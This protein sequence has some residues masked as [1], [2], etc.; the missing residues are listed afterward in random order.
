MK[1]RIDKALVEHKIC[2]S[3]SQAQVLI[4]KRVVYCNGE[5]VG[6]SN[7]QVQPNDKL[8]V[9][10]QIFVSRGAY[11]L[12]QA[13]DEFQI[14]IQG[15]IIADVGASTG[16][17]T[18][19]LLHKGAE[20]VFCIDVGRDQLHESLRKDERVINLEGHNIKD[21]ELKERVDLCV[22]DLSFISILKVIDKIMSLLKPE[23]TAVIL[24]KPQFEAG[25]EN[26]GKKAVLKFEQSE[27]IFHQTCLELEKLGYVIKKEIESPIKGKE[28]NTEFLIELGSAN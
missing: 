9:K 8:E 25:R 6:K 27:K 28:G 19:I 16:G 26:L 23:G 3:R 7:Y 17:F 12:A 4:E 15:K 5:L 1:Q 14:S 10:E 24:V 20:R 18:Q 13:I 11:K 21:V 2:S 22:V